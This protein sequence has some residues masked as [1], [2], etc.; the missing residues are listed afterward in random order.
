MFG[1][2]LR[3]TG[4]ISLASV[5]ASFFENHDFI[6]SSR[7]DFTD[8]P[9]STSRCNPDTFSFPHTLLLLVPQRRDKNNCVPSTKFDASSFN[10]SLSN[11]PI[12]SNPLANQSFADCVHLF[13]NSSSQD[14]CVPNLN[15][16]T[17]GIKS[18]RGMRVLIGTDVS[19]VNVSPI[20]FACQ[21]CSVES[22]NPTHTDGIADIGEPSVVHAALAVLRRSN[23]PIKLFTGTCFSNKFH[24]ASGAFLAIVIT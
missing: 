22:E 11:I 5:D 13:V 12:V 23:P 19:F 16:N 7:I 3:I 4:I 24:N 8:F 21:T 15:H 20:H 18:I 17:H 2:A 9:I 14:A 6:A 1:L 10:C